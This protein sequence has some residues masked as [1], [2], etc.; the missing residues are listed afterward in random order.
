MFA[1]RLFRSAPSSTIVINIT[2]LRVLKTRNTSNDNN[3]IIN[4]RIGRHVA[5]FLSTQGF[6][7]KYLPWV[8]WLM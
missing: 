6:S 7:I 5:A 2:E 3:N 4:N 1:N 8:E